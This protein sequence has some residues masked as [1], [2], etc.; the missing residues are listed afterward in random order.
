MTLIIMFLYSD[1]EKISPCVTCDVIH[2]LTLAL[3]WLLP[4][5]PRWLLSVG[6]VAEAE[7]IVREAATFNNIEL[8]ED[9]RLAPVQQR[10]DTRRR[11]ILDL[12]RSPNMRTKTL[13]LF[14]NW[15][16]NAFAYYGLSLNMG[17]LTG[18][19]DI[20]LNFTV[21]GLLEIP[22]YLAALVIL[23]CWGRR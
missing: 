15:F 9:F 8:P 1:I 7:G 17:Q 20:Y 3:Y 18:G 10:A 14:Y 22:A 5:S 16:V 2:G 6:R 23:R 21:S 4:E 19:A 13:I 12:L 11:T